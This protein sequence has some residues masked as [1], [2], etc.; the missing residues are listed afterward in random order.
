MTLHDNNTSHYSPTA[1]LNAGC[2]FDYQGHA[3]FYRDSGGD[4][5]ALL[6][7]HGFPTASW[8]W[9]EVWDALAKHFRLIA[10]DMLGFGFSSKPQHHRYSIH[11]QADIHAQLLAHLGI[12]QSHALVHD[13]GV[14]VMQELLARQLEDGKQTYLSAC[15]LNGGLY[16]EMHR[17]RF[18]QKMMLSPLGPLLSLL[19]N[20]AQF[21]KSFSAVF[22]PATQPTPEAL[23]SFWQ[24]IR[25]NNGH[26]IFHR[27]IRYMSDRKTHRSRWT[28]AI[29]HPA[30]PVRLI[31]GPEDPVSGQH[32][33]EHYKQRVKNADTVS[34]QGIGHYPQ[35]EAP[36]AVI[37]HYLE[38][39]LPLRYK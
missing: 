5:P 3:I 36:Q 21:S 12:Q 28:N 10:P 32:L 37:Q 33:L 24:L 15:F 20:K 16:P 13:Y 25:H 31:N 14:S 35:I 22:G 4:L 17:A 11:E 1:W 7:I 9:H 30:I 26:R 39:A 34:L 27:L 19:T 8:D 2:T 6:L 29:E 18:I 23:D 38:F